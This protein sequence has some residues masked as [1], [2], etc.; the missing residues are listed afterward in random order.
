MTK[1]FLICILWIL[2]LPVAALTQSTVTAELSNTVI[3]I[4]D[5]VKLQIRVT[6]PGNDKV[7]ID[8]NPISEVEGLEIVS[9][10]A[11]VTKEDPG[12]NY[13][14][15][16]VMIT[17]FDSG[18]YVVPQIPVRLIGADG[19]IETL[20]TNPIPL[21]VN[22]IPIASDSLQLA[23][24]KDIE[25]EDFTFQDSLPYL[26]GG[27]GVIIIGLLIWWFFFK[28]HDDQ[29]KT[30]PVIIRPAHE[31]ALDK[32]EELQ[33]QELWQKGRIKDYYSILT[34]VARE[35]LENRFKIPALENTTG[36]ILQ[37][38]NGA[39]EIDQ[40]R[41]Q[42]LRQILTSSD[43]VK[44]AKAEPAA[45]FHTEAMDK[46]RQFIIITQ[47]K[48]QEEVKEEENMEET[49]AV[50]AAEEQKTKEPN[51]ENG[52]SPENEAIKE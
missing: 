28:K 45:A 23:P 40:D 43:M 41:L 19:Q 35:Y 12:V 31:V 16:N 18:E 11:P 4:G 32:L 21:T 26:L 38:L 30:R 42:T 37:K 52:E 50:T 13:L 7:D 36:E 25:R 22:T 20:Q 8:L 46:T 51:E 9:E 5:Q 10:T 33:K 39:P 17:S 15:K 2:L 6:Q 14:E 44:F 49:E 24:I 27:A 47:A 29:G 3:M 34:Y 48:P 1:R